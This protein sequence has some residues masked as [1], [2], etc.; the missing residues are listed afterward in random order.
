MLN[1]N[2]KPTQEALGCALIDKASAEKVIALDVQD[3]ETEREKAILTAM[4]ALGAERKAITLVSVDDATG[5]IY[6]DYLV[7]ISTAA[8]T[9]ALVD[10]YIRGIKEASKRRRIRA[11][12][13]ELYNAACDGSKS[14][15][16]ITAEFA[17]RVDAIADI[18]GGTVSAWDAVFALIEEIDRKDEKKA[19]V[20]IPL[21]D[22]S[23]GGM[24]GGRLY[25]VG[26]RP[27]TGKTALAISAAYNTCVNGSVLFCS[28]EMQP[29]EIMGRIL[30]RLS[31]VNSQA[32]SYKT[33][34]D[35][36]MQKL[37]EYYTTA[38][39]LPIQFGVNCHT[40]G[41]VR[42]E[43][44]RMQKGGDLRLIVIDYLQLMSSGRRAES[45]RVEVGQISRG[46]KQ[47]SIELNV[48]VL[49]LSQLNRA[50]EERAS[51]APTMSDM[52]ESGDIEQDSDAIVL[53]YQLPDDNDTFVQ[54]CDD[55]GYKAVRILLDKNRQGKSGLAIDT[56]FD[57]ATM[58]FIS[59][60]AV[61]EGGI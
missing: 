61:L 8:V 15:D 48:P 19:Y 30:A 36:Q 52:R 5:S 17:H 22:Q 34:T 38:G 10:E 58:T 6:T 27:A 49:A 53:M 42:A 44:L 57:G 40:P 41:K 35:K 4:K 29:S 20:G 60:S 3:M 12:A 25:V 26:A 1:P 7:E 9:T 33:L 2:T 59:K 37:G 24:S 46:L 18:E 32:I 28:Y 13:T 39:R 50:S 31:K 16:E 14:L 55:S 56:A 45:R 54:M 23:L 21:L 11:A 47:L 43:A 51:K